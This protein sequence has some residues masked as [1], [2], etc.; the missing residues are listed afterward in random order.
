MLRLRH[1]LGEASPLIEASTGVKKWEKHFKGKTGGLETYAK[2]DATLFD[3]HGKP[4]DRIAAGAP[5]T[6]YVDDAYSTKIKIKTADGLECYMSFDNV[7]KAVGGGVSGIKLKL[8]DFNLFT[9]T[10]WDIH[11]LSHEL[12]D[13]LKDKTDIDEDLKKYLI[14]LIKFWSRSGTT[15]SERVDHGG[16]GLD[17]VKTYF[18]PDLKG[19]PEIKKDFGEILGA[20]GCV[21]HQILQDV[22]I[23][24]SKNAHIRI[25]FS[26]SEPLIDY[27]IVDGDQE[28]A[29]SAKAEG[30]SNT[31]KPK[32]IIELLEKAG[33]LSKW[34]DTPEYEF[35]RIIADTS[36]VMAPFELVKYISPETISSAVIEDAKMIMKP[37]KFKEPIG[38]IELYRP[39]I[40]YLKAHG[41]LTTLVDPTIGE[42]FY[43]TEKRALDFAKK[44]LRFDD[45]FLDATSSKIYYLKYDITKAKPEGD[46][47]VI[48]SVATKPEKVFLR[49]KN[50]RTRA[51]D[52]IGIQV[53]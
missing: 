4:I 12:I 6:V 33:N 47:K 26:G 5:I 17:A 27:Y 40:D 18:K 38:N 34:I 16:K 23:T 30:N 32:N 42:L 46:F 49:S 37:A 52:R 19:L 2:K 10:D 43:A 7:A 15:V 28:Y 9:K 25:P 44:K 3:E 50:S 39:L 14:A 8:Q 41:S 45:L 31:V 29:I 21:A 36:I 35:L 20:V 24:L 22:G 51:A 53:E 48:D 1:F 11:E 13:E